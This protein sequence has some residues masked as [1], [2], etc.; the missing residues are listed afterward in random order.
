VE[1]AGD[2]ARLLGDLIGDWRARWQQPEMPFYFVQLPNFGG[3]PTPNTWAKLREAQSQV[4]ATLPGTGMVVTIDQ[5]DSQDIHPTNKAEVAR[6]LA[7]LALRATYGQAGA[8]S[9]VYQSMEVEG[10]RIR[11][12]FA[13]PDSLAKESKET[14]KQFTIAGNDQKFVS[15]SAVID[16]K[17]VVVSSRLVPNPVAVRYAWS[18]DPVGGNLRGA[19]GEPVSP[20]RTDQ[21]NER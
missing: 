12:K 9:P 20:F 21:W 16:G 7:N 3:W 8:A 10:S 14:L 15:A 6:R 18:N 2:Y 13:N 4:A 19:N 5:G 1:R 17:D 11:L